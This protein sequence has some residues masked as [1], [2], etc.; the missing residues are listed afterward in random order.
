MARPGTGGSR[1]QSAWNL[2]NF[3]RGGR[4]RGDQAAGVG[5]D[6]IS[7][8]VDKV[9]DGRDGSSPGRRSVL[10]GNPGYTYTWRGEA[11]PRRRTR[12][13]ASGEGPSVPAGR[14]VSWLR[15]CGALLLIFG[16]TWT[17]PQARL[18]GVTF[19]GD[20]LLGL[21]AVG[22]LIVLALS[23]RLRWT[24][25]HA[26][27]G[28][29]LATQ[30]FTSILNMKER[31]QGLKFSAIYLAGFACFALAAE[32][33]RRQADRRLSVR[34]WIVVGGIVSVVGT[35]ATVMAQRSQK[36]LWGS[37]LADWLASPDG[38]QTLVF[39]AQGTFSEHN[40]FS[41]FLLVSFALGLWLWCRDRGR[42]RLWVIASIG[43]IVFGLVFGLT[44][45]AW[46][47]SAA[48]VVFWWRTKRPG[49]P[50]LAMVGLLFAAAFSLQAALIG[51]SPLVFRVL[52]PVLQAEDYNLRGRALANSAT[53]AS[54][55]KRPLLGYGAGSVN[56]L[57]VVLQDG[58]RSPKPWTANLVLFVLHDSGLL[59]LDTLVALLTVLGFKGWR[60]VRRGTGTEMPP[61]SVPL[62]ASGA[63]LLFAYQF[64]HALWLMY[65]YVYLGLLTSAIDD[66]AADA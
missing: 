57:L 65:P 8:R 40:L 12:L 16:A 63:A 41:S 27:L 66:R 22:V 50:R 7:G 23:R 61:V 52:R 24:G 6:D 28:I 42:R 36:R 20:R 25:V 19:T 31:P 10:I 30:V 37:N 56:D 26:A 58:T 45:A 62:L 11:S 3:H 9:A 44:R 39:A 14:S 60:A 4:T 59:G 18:C 35:L 47:S 46:L 64:T 2:W 49:W 1:E 48:M 13:I 38:G 54:W 51:S 32:C 55:R 53:L 34:G 15:Q 29:F 5:E 43:A 33:S 21:V 17:L